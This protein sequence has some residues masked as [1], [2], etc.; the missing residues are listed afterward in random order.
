MIDFTQTLKMPN[1][2]YQKSSGFLPK[3]AEIKVL[4]EVDGTWKEIGK[5]ILNISEFINSPCKEQLF[6]LT[7]SQEKD[8]A[9]CLSIE[10]DSHKSE[11]IKSPEQ[12]F[13]DLVK[14]LND[15][16][17]K[18][19]WLKSNYDDVIHQNQELELEVSYLRQ[20]LSILRLSST[21]EAQEK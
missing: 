11:E 4:G 14:Q 8:S 21:P 6:T 1:T 9:L 16:K 18:I 19:S 12:N 7:K 17:N 20:E 10:T 15:S 2:I 13:D 3:E 5:L